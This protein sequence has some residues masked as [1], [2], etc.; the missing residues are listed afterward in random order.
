MKL[1]TYNVNG[2]ASRLSNLLDWLGREA[3]DVVCL[4]ELKAVDR[5]FPALALQEAGYDAIWHGQSGWNGVAILSKSGTPIEVRR[6]LT[7][8][9]SD[10][11]ARYLEAAVD[12]ILIG[13]LYLPNG[14]P[15]P[16]PKFTYKLAW[17]DR[18][19]RHARKL[20][21]SGHQVA[22]MGDF[23]VVPTNFDIYDPKHWRK[24]ALLQPESRKAYQRLL[25]QGWTDALR[26]EHPHEAVFTFWDYFR[27]RWQ[28]NTG[29]R[30]DH[31]LLSPDVAKR[32]IG[33]GVDTW[34]R[35]ESH[36]SD[37]APAWVELRP[38]RQ[39]KSVAKR[40]A[41]ATKTPVRRKRPP[42]ASTQR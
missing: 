20:L 18:L 25:A 26:A 29:L 10:T 28:S 27:N 40:A 31:L 9:A 11:D 5:A 23:N 33:A 6:G 30:I 3:P 38:L 24:D 36:A 12:G 16:G 4:Q 21:N 19:L 8:N 1:A 22:L 2:I 7:G 34:V 13:C 37:H 42:R 35:G 15:Q 32:V 17:F 39:R 41:P 14:N